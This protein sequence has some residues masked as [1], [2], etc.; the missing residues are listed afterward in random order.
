MPRLSAI[1][2]CRRACLC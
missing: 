1:K 2:L